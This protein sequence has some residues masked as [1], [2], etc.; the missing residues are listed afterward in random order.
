MATTKVC[1]STEKCIIS[2]DIK[3]TAMVTIVM[4]D[5][6]ATIATVVL[7]LKSQ[8]SLETQ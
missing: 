2:R 4:R 1:F 6:G 7:I 3:V 8:S 5:S